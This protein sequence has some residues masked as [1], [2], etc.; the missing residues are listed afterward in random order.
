MVEWADGAVPEGICWLSGMA[1]TGK[2]TIARTV[3]EILDSQGRLGASF[4][5]SEGRGDVGHA[6]KFFSTLA[7]QM[8]SKSLLIKRHLGAVI[9]ERP[10][11]IR[12]AALFEQY[13]KLFL[14][15]MRLSR[16]VCPL[17]HPLVVVVDALDECGEEDDVHMILRLLANTKDMET[18]KLR[19]FLTS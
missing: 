15:P 3:A 17:L 11:V 19:K 5:F 1:G 9:A 14:E 4:F 10:S 8:A 18:L 2:S 13:D 7:V 12:Q 6:R 16:H